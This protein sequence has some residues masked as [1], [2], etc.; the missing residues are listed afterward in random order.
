MSN[1]Y[2]ELDDE[3]IGKLNGRCV[4]EVFASLRNEI[5]ENELLEHFFASTDDEYNLVEDE[6]KRILN[7]GV[8]SGFIVKS[9][10]GYALPSLETMYELDCDE[11]DDDEE[12][13]MPSDRY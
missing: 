10:N 12:V 6:L 4:M 2:N 7:S 8:V 5:T 1:Q 9:D 3:T 13:V 11:D